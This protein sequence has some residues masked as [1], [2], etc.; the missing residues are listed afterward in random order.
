MMVS[1]DEDGSIT[2]YASPMELIQKAIEDGEILSEKEKEEVME[3]LMADAYVRAKD[4]EDRFK[5]K[6]SDYDVFYG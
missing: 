4:R 2:T 5:M 6:P 3:G 1:L